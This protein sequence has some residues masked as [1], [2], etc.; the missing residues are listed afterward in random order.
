[1]VVVGWQMS[2][3]IRFHARLFLPSL[4][5]VAIGIGWISVA[6]Q[7]IN[8]PRNYL[9]LSEMPL[10]QEHVM[11]KFILGGIA[12]GL[13]GVTLIFLSACLERVK[14][15]WQSWLLWGLIAMEIVIGHMI[16]GGIPRSA[17][18]R[19]QSDVAIAWAPFRISFT[20]GLPISFGITLAFLV[21]SRLVKRQDVIANL[22]KSENL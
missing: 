5:F 21:V 22:L 20:A 8:D 11:L 2:K 6:I 12:G 3:K 19:V 14:K 1:M 9:S 15:K 17:G 13:G 18:P 4:I 16:I 7:R 10:Q